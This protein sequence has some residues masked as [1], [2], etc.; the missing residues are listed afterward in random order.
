MASI[1]IIGTGYVGLCTAVGFAL[2]GHYVIASTKDRSKADLINKGRPPFYEPGLDELLKRVVEE[3]RLK[4]VVDRRGAL[5]ESDITFIT[6]ATPS[7]PT[8]SIDLSLVRDAAQ[9][10]GEALKDKPGYHLVVVKSTVVPGTTMEVVKP[11]IE[12]RSG[13]EAGPDFG[14]AMN[15]EFLREGSAMYDTLNPDRVVIGELDKRSGDLLEELYQEFYEGKVPILRTS[16]YTA[17]LIKYANNAF[18]AMKISFINSVAN[19]C[20]RLPGVD[21]VEVARAIGMDRRIS[22]HFLNAG[23]G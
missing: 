10:I 17:E 15:P 4:C 6:V 21:V 9:E 20:E 5:L 8:G 13:K 19:I 3:G 18:L 16:L 11:I 1:S 2:K 12:E 23:V 7:L 22:P 14:L